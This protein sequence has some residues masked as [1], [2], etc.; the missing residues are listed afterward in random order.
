ME[1]IMISRIRNQKRLKDRLFDYI[2]LILSIISIITSILGII[3]LF[4]VYE[5]MNGRPYILLMLIFIIGVMG[6]KQWRK[7]NID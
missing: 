1:N 7:E 2:I 6:Y 4:F 3:V 5:L